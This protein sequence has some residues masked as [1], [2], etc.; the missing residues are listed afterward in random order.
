MVQKAKESSLTLPNCRMKGARSATLS[1][2]SYLWGQVQRPLR[3]PGIVPPLEQAP[4]SPVPIRVGGMSFPTSLLQ[5]VSPSWLEE[6]NSP[7][8][9][10]EEKF[11][12]ITRSQLETANVGMRWQNL[13]LELQKTHLPEHRAAPESLLSGNLWQPPCLLSWRRRWPQ[14]A[15]CLGLC[16][17]N[18][19]SSE[20][21]P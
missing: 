19:T 21:R 18:S 14:T 12:P 1:E 11:W 16:I 6:A 5:N 3:V 10:S 4:V 9:S 2:A 8:L 7:H 17:Q 15:G 13:F 20:S